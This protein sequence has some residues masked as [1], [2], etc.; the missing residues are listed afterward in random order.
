M[1]IEELIDH[2]NTV[3]T[4]GCAIPN[5]LPPHAIQNYVERI[6]L[7]LFWRK[8]QNAVSKVYYFLDKDV[9]KQEEYTKY[10]Y[11]TLPC[12]IKE[13][14]FIKRVDRAYT[15]K[16]GLNSP[17]LSINMGVANNSYLSSYITTI[18]DIGVY[19]SILD[20]FSDVMDNFNRQTVKYH[21]NRNNHRLNILTD[22][23]YHLV[24]ETYVAIPPE[25]LFDDD[26]FQRYI[27]GWAKQ[28]L[29]NLLGHVDFTIA[30]GFK[31]NTATLIQQGTDE[32]A[33]V[34]EEIEKMSTTPWFISMKR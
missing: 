14:T 1:T 17:N 22:V 21:Y 10:S 5:Q 34:L 6:A 23:K 18:G 2:V 11:I 26:L 30:G 19:K 7:P 24:L 27:I 4:Y 25:D 9:F 13:V 20:S 3:I 29:G 33:K 8:Y 15:Y 16:I 31:F 32:M 12:E 28:S